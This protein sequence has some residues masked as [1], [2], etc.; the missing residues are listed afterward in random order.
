MSLE[1]TQPQGGEE[2]R[3]AQELSLR[4][5]KPPCDLPGYEPRR[6]LGAGAFGEVWVALDRNTGRQVAIKFYAHR[7]GLDWSLLSREVEKLAFLSADRYVVQLLEVG[8]DAEPPYYVMEYVEQGS[9]EDRLK[10][11]GPLPAEE[12]VTLFR[13]V[14]TGLLHAHGK[15]VLHCDLKP[16]NVLLDQDLRPRLAD[17]GQ[18]RLSNEQSP[19]LGT[20]FYMAPEQ[21][22]LKAMPDARWDVYALGALLYAM[23]TGSPPHR[24]EK[25]VALLEDAP[26]LNERLARYRRWIQGSPAPAKHRAVAGVDRMLAEI[27]DQCVVANPAAR[28]ANV[29]SVLDALD[30]RTRRRARRPLVVLG[31]IG[32]AVLLLVMSLVAWRVSR[33]LVADSN[34]ALTERALESNRFA[35]EFVAKAVANEVEKRYA[36]VEKV[37]N[38]P[39]FQEYLSRALTDPDMTMA[40]SQLSNPEEDE[41][42]LAHLRDDYRK[43]PTLKPLQRYLDDLNREP[44]ITVASWFVTDAHGLQ[45]ARTPDDETVGKNFGWRSYFTGMSADEPESWRPDSDDHIN[46]TF[47]SPV[48]RSQAT[49][50]WVVAISTPVQR[51]HTFLGVVTLTVE[52]G[53]LIE[54]KTGEQQFAVLVDER[55][56]PNRGLILQHPLFERVLKA[57][58]KLPDHFQDY[59]ISRADLPEEHER[60]VHY[61]DP[62]AK[63]PLGADFDRPWLAEEAPVKVLGVDS[64]WYVVVQQSYDTAIGATLAAL[65]H[66]LE[67]NGM[68]ALAL[69]TF[70]LTL[71]WGF[72]IR[73]LNDQRPRK[74]ALALAANGAPG[75]LTPQKR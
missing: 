4:R 52:V 1:L 73:I 7:G 50:N 30:A 66:R 25:S 44:Q 14:V 60:Q 65:Q 32:P 63:D 9:L 37:A 42:V 31:A 10:N 59:R 33:G 3:R 21:A 13:E 17:F 53:R 43:S 41:L 49:N 72:V 75:E 67:A 19:A 28:F 74:G 22:D 71:L 38:D 51:N 15:G 46:D 70:V 36:E 55:R 18:S 69:A 11:Q 24:E 56:G 64:G 45:L 20:L 57:R 35:A 40:R 2:Q 29:Q 48:F 61:A 8:W 39:L 68:L 27:I 12:A 34:T 54:L 62:L 6:F 58:N 23:L 16:A 26:D 5:T 47:L